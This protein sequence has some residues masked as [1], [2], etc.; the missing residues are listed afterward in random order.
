MNRILAVIVVSA[1][2]LGTRVA[3]AEESGGVPLH[4]SVSRRLPLGVAV[5]AAPGV[6]LSR[7]GPRGAQVVGVTG[8]VKLKTYAELVILEGQAESLQVDGVTRTRW[9]LGIH[10]G[11]ELKPARLA[12]HL[13]GCARAVARTAARI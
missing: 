13:W 9:W 6:L 7:R 3:A 10:L 1:T 11:G 12:G 2:L 8:F 4:Y 5:E